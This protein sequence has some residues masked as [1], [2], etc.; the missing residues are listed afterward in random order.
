M[1]ETGPVPP[2][3]MIGCFVVAGLIVSITYSINWSQVF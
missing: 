3:L 1:K 2:A